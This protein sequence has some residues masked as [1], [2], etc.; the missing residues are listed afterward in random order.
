M[1]YRRKCFTVGG[2][3]RRIQDFHAGRGAISFAF[4]LHNLTGPICVPLVGRA[5]DRF[6]ARRVILIGTAIFALI[7]ISSELLGTRIA[8]LYLFYTVLGLVSGGASPVPYGAV[9]SR[10]FDQRRGL[11]LGLMMLGL[12]IGAITLPLIAHRLIAIF[13]SRRP[14]A[15]RRSQ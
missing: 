10:W 3:L 1:S 8:Y 14:Y 6:G 15:T 13:G 11:A 12:G 2:L 5:I 9:A 4:T 7:L